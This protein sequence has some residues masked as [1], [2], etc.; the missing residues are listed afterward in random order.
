MTEIELTR[1]FVAIIDECDFEYISKYRWY[2]KTN[3]TTD[4]LYAMRSPGI[5]MHRV[6]LEHHG[7]SVDGLEVDHI[8]GN[9]LNNILSNL[10]V[11]THSQNM[12]NSKLHCNN[13]S[14]YKGI[15]YENSSRSAR[16]W[17]AQVN[18]DGKHKRKC[19]YRIE[20]AVEWRNKMALDVYGEYARE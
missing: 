7:I 6:I 10:R 4:I 12:M 20:D 1:G 2:V 3:S 11:A 19:F 18:I 17:V 13:S 9:G 14:G 16:R 8:D 15:R 5:L